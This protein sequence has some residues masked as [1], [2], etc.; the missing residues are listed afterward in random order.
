MTRAEAAASGLSRFYTGLPCKAGHRAERFVS[1]RQCVACN[2]IKARQREAL[3]GFTDPSFRMYR[4]TLRRT[5]MALRGRASPANA[6]GC[7]HP[8]LRDHIAGQF[9]TGMCWERYRQWEVDHIRP[10]SSA[11]TMSELISLCHF[12]NLQPLW[13]S[14]NLRKGGA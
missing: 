6:V 13:R 5:G 14:E 9:R 11:R 12:S 10:L 3:R 4:N 2:A 1:N 8:E 7:D